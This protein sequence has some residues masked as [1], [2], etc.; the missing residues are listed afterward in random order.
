[1]LEEKTQAA[2]GIGGNLTTTA[3]ANDLRSNF[4]PH[5]WTMIVFSGLLFWINTGSTVGWSQR[6]FRGSLFYFRA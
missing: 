4:G 5:G 6:D 1:M 2:G 3:A